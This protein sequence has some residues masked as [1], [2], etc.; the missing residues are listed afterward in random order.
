M[1]EKIDLYQ[2]SDLELIFE[3]LEE[4]DFVLPKPSNY[5]SKKH[6]HILP[7]SHVPMSLDMTPKQYLMGMEDEELGKKPVK[8]ILSSA[9]YELEMDK[10]RTFAFSNID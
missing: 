3:D 6:V 4:G 10:S 5:S 1:E 9:I 7:F 8:D 2:S